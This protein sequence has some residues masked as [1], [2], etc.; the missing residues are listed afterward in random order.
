MH[1]HTSQDSLQLLCGNGCKDWTSENAMSSDC[2]TGR[3]AAN[4]LVARK[5]FADT[6]KY[7]NLLLALGLS[8]SNSAEID[9]QGE[10]SCVPCVCMHDF[11]GISKY[12]RRVLAELPDVTC[13]SLVKAQIWPACV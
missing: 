2:T 8:D 11:G 13:V 12:S 10:W 7:S 4:A 5:D 6:T 3:S 1:T 9:A